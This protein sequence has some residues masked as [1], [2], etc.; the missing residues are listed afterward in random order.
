MIEA[1][2]C[3]IVI[4]SI[5]QVTMGKYTAKWCRHAIRKCGESMAI[6]RDLV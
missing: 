5:F 6:L 1:L 4:V 2:A 3:A